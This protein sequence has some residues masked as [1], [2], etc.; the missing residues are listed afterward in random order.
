M[1]SKQNLIKELKTLE[2]SS[3]SLNSNKTRKKYLIEHG[4]YKGKVVAVPNAGVKTF[5]MDAQEQRAKMGIK[6]KK[7][8]SLEDDF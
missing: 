6:E 8:H 5:V 7:I 4:L 2:L 3:G 1:K